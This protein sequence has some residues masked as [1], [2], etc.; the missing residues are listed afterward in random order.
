MEFISSILNLNKNDINY[1]K[2]NEYNYLN[3]NESR[4]KIYSWSFANYQNIVIEKISGKRD[5]TSNDFYIEINKEG[6]IS[7]NYYKL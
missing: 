1:I 3:K 6:K 2:N 7:L 4:F 5:N